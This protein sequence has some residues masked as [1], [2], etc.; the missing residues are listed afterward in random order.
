MDTTILDEII[1][2]RVEPHIYA[3]K[4]NTV[5]NYLKVG[6][7]Y[8]PVSERLKEWKKHFPDLQKEFE[9]KATVNSDIFFRDFAVHQYLENELNKIR[10]QKSD[11]KKGVYYSNEFFKETKKD[12]IE[13]AITDITADSTPKTAP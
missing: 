12:D 10:L 3:F 5:P 13:N 4:T 6:D 11:I 7:T 1:I 2:G 8:R 9:N